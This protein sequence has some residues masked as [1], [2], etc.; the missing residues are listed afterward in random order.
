MRVSAE[1]A[2]PADAA[3]RRS[4]SRR[5]CAP[6]SDRITI[7]IIG[8]ALLNGKPLGRRSSKLYLL[9]PGSKMLYYRYLAV[10]L[11]HTSLSSYYF[12]DNL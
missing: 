10:E 3:A 2:I 5:F 4:R 11:S 8:A 12:S 7:P 1:Q 6:E 9:P